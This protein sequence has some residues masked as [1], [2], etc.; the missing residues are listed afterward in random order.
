[1]TLSRVNDVPQGREQKSIHMFKSELK[2]QSGGQPDNNLQVVVI[3]SKHNTC[4]KMEIVI[5]KRNN[6]CSESMIYL[7]CG[8]T[9]A[10]YIFCLK[11]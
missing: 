5:W 10:S 8:D 4:W 11:T 6:I 2:L 7:T 1:M 9:T 3:C